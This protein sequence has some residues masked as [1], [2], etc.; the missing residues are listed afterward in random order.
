VVTAF[1]TSFLGSERFARKPEI[2][3]VSRTGN[4]RAGEIWQTACAQRDVWGADTSQQ[5][6]SLR[7][8]V[9]SSQWDVIHHLIDSIHM[10]V[11]CMCI[12]TQ[13]PLFSI[14]Y[15]VRITISCRMMFDDYPLDAH[16]CQFQVGS[17]KWCHVVSM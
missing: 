2:H 10:Y 11:V 7:I 6:H 3:L 13:K 16:T 1:L 12:W 15:R 4:L 8:G 17:C 14:C 9:S 5:N